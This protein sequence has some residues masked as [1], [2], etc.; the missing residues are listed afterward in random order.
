M[1]GPIIEPLG[2]AGAGPSITKDVDVKD[3]SRRH[4]KKPEDVQQPVASIATELREL[5][6]RQDQLLLLLRKSLDL[7]NP[8]PLEDGELRPDDSDPNHP[9]LDISDPDELENNNRFARSFH[10]DVTL[11]DVKLRETLEETVNL[12]LAAFQIEGGLGSLSTDFGD[13]VPPFFFIGG[14]SS[15]AANVST[16]GSPEKPILCL[17]GFGDNGQEVIN[18]QWGELRE[19]GS[20]ESAVD[21]TKLTEVLRSKWRES[22]SDHHYSNHEFK[23][24]NYDMDRY[25]RYLDT[26]VYPEHFLVSP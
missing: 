20:G 10:V 4:G 15:R 2:D 11:D 18:I 3:S 6:N 13:T 19:P 21:A 7:R 26:K 8:F 23:L 25:P 22:R 14:T 16:S 5:V 12:F 9:N 1:S 17:E 24:L